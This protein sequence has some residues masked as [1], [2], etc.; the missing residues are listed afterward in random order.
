MAWYESRDV[1]YHTS[2]KSAFNYQAPHIEVLVS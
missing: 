1:T 2:I